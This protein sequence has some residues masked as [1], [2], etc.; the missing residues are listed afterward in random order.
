[1]TC[2]GK[3]MHLHCAERV[4]R[5]TMTLAQKNRC[6]ECRTKYPSTDEGT[7]KQLRVWVDKGKPWAQTNLANK[8]EFGDGVPLSYEQAIEYYNM[9]IK[10]GDPNAMYGLALMYADGLGVAQ[11]FETAAE[12]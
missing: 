5:S 7:V 1:M 12:L 8:Y 10:Q 6:H 4:K 2:C 11:S 3:A 9:A